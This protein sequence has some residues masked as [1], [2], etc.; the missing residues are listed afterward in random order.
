M[1]GYTHLLWRGRAFT[2]YSVILFTEQYCP[3]ITKHLEFNGLC[4]WLNMWLTVLSVLCVDAR[5]E[6]NQIMGS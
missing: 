2:D 6:D 5:K 1:T 3:D 4:A